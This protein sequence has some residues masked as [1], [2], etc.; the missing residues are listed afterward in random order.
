MRAGDVEAAL[1]SMRSFLAGIPYHLG[2]RSERGFQTTFW[3]VFTLLGAQIDTE[4][5][6]ATGRVDAVMKLPDAIYVFE[7][8]Y[9][10]SAEEALEQI[11]ERGYLVPFEHDGRRLFKVGV[12]FSEKTQTVEDWI[13]R[14]G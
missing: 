2:S 10:K 11:D 14:E 6:T 12:N 8:K 7:F 4:V 13:V 9:N 5:R 3:L 1:G